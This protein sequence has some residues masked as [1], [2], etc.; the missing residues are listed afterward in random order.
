[1]KAFR[2]I[3]AA[4][5]LFA[6]MLYPTR[7]AGERTD[8]GACPV[9]AMRA[10]LL[11]RDYPAEYLDTLIPPQISN[12]YQMALEQDAYFYG[13]LT[14]DAGPGSGDI[15]ADQLNFSVAVSYRPI[16]YDGATYFD[17]I[18]LSVHYRWAALPVI[19]GTD[20]IAVNW[21]SSVLNY[22]GDN[23]F[24]AY[25]YFRHPG[26]SRWET[27]ET[28][29]QPNTLAR[30]GL[31]IDT[32]LDSGAYLDG[33]TMWGYATGLAGSVHLALRPNGVLSMKTAPDQVTAI[34]A[35]YT[36]NKNPL[37]VG[38][39]YTHSESGVS[40]APGALRESTG[41]ECEIGYT[42]A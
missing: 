37:G 41:A 7:A 36:H 5:I 17:E 10:V 35:A 40:A 21:D 16:R 1:M 15:P 39:S 12:L 33:G 42:E 23:S 13:F 22:G 20:A 11:S 2:P 6:L 8:T 19:R 26:N 25:D 27:Y 14:A 30:G 29:E 38:L 18:F 4:L 24:T 31:G 32:Y 28:W 3:L 34:R 9:E